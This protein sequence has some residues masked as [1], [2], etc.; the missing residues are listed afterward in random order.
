[1]F[2]DQKLWNP[3]LGAA[4]Y[5]PLDYTCF[6]AFINKEALVLLIS[7]VFLVKCLFANRP[8]VNKDR[9]EKETYCPSLIKCCL[10]KRHRTL[11]LVLQSTFSP[12]YTCFAAFIKKKVGTL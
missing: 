9:E 11:L 5:I 6:T 1:M 4:I 3:V 7:T 12:D 2:F 10:A 8:L